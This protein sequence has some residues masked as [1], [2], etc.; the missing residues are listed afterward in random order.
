[1]AGGS[2]TCSGKGDAMS[3]NRPPKAAEIIHQMTIHGHTRTDPYYWLRER[4]NPEVLAYLAA[5]NEYT[6][7]M[8]AHTEE[9]REQLYKEITGRIKQD[10]ESVPVLKNGYFYYDRFMEG[11]EYPIY[12]RKKKTLETDEEVVLDV[13]CVAEGADYCHVVAL[14][15]SGNNK[16]LA[17]S[18]DKVGRL[19][20]VLC[21]KDLETGED[22]SDRIEM[23]SGWGVAWANDNRTVFYA[24]KHPE[25]LRPCRIF[26]HILGEDPSGDEYIYFEEDETYR[27]GIQKSKSKAW[28]FINSSSTLSSEY[29]VLPADK[30]SGEFR[31]FQ[32]RER[33]HEYWIDH[34][35]DHFYILTNLDARNN[36]LM[37]T[38]VK[39]NVT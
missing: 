19:Q 1:M 38:P 13:N 2:S 12:C 9:R 25:T 15:I 31:I 39:R 37:R 14:E 22:L 18:V 28:L 10:D 36:R 3:E 6:K 5:E 32:P 27:V 16:L 20:F 4:D 26:R 8:L 35:G 7:T 11:H 29:R 17:Y 21:F 33:K 24:K 34:Y 23:T 30:P